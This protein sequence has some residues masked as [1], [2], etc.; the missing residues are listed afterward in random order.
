MDELT[1]SVTVTFTDELQ[2]LID[3]SHDCCARIDDRIHEQCKRIAEAHDQELVAYK[4]A[5]RWKDEQQ[6]VTA[7]DA[8]GNERHKAL[9]ELGKLRFKGEDAEYGDRVPPEIDM[10]SVVDLLKCFC[11]PQDTWPQT[12]A[13]A[14]DTLIH[15]L[16]GD[17]KQV[18]LK[19]LYGIWKEKQD[20]MDAGGRDKARDDNSARATDRHVPH[21][22][23]NPPHE[24][25]APITGELRGT[26]RSI[27][28]DDSTL[29]VSKAEFDR[30]CDAIDAVHAGLERENAELKMKYVNANRKSINLERELDAV[31]GELKLARA[32][33][34]TQ[35]N[36]FEQATTARE[37]WKDLYE[38]S[39][40]HVHDLEHDV[41]MWRD[42]AEDMRMERD[43]ALKEHHAWAP[44]SHYMMLPKDADGE[45]VHVGDVMEWP[46]TG[47]T[48]EVVGVGDGVLFYTD[49]DECAEW[50]GASTKHHHHE[51][52]I[53]DLLREF[54]QEMNENMGMYTSEAIDA[55][56]WR[57]ADAK[58][59]DKFAA[60]LR[61][62]DADA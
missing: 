54:A 45:P 42:R 34:I 15:L 41:E 52:T 29:S 28:L 36:N 5:L 43:D 11:E 6:G 61:L 14:R 46:T 48:F 2:A 59:V 20:G 4:L 8:L 55:D 39:L 33:A 25:L 58:T 38:Q 23:D 60:K 50:T 32:D 53:E 40:E 26:M 56:E 18:T 30:L 31:G 22:G 17:Q 35:R 12:F 3:Y 62:S 47:E 7:Y 44:E 21:S 27:A 10:Q 9:C 49:D 51:P 16:G 19:D 24:G 37:H 57:N 1:K 13:K